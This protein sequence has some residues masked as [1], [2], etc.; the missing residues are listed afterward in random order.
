M[1][2]K[3][4]KLGMVNERVETQL[5]S[6][7]LCSIGI[8]RRSRLFGQLPGRNKLKAGSRLLVSRFPRNQIHRVLL[9]V[10]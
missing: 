4:S 9:R 7:S 8:V 6:P 10:L 1:C 2:V 3:F 5:K